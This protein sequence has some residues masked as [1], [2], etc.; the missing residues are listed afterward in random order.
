MNF[1][2][3]IAKRMSQQITQNE[4]S[5]LSCLFVCCVKQCNTFNN[6][7]LCKYNQISPTHLINFFLGEEELRIILY[8]YEPSTCYSISYNIIYKPDINAE[9]YQ[10]YD[11]KRKP[12]DI[13]IQVDTPGSLPHVPSTGQ[14]CGWPREPQQH[15][16]CLAALG[17]RQSKKPVDWNRTL[18]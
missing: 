5:A 1:S 17:L 12:S 3:N 14:C 8:R 6:T 7:E 9:Q 16:V 10:P 2:I 15:E 18:E 4:N 13:R 11:V